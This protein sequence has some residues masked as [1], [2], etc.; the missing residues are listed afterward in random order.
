MISFPGPKPVVLLVHGLLFEGR[1]WIANLPS[2][3]L[4][5][6]LSDA[7]YDVWIVNI[8]GTTWSRSHQKFSVDQ[9]EFWEFR[10]I[11]ERIHRDNG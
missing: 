9:Q 3:S 2:N 7:G 4:G 10:Y 6:F 5:F 11:Q 8:R 1:C